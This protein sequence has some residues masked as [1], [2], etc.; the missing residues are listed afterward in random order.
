MALPIVRRNDVTQQQMT[1]SLA[2]SFLAK[3]AVPSNIQSRAL[4]LTVAVESNSS[5][6]PFLGS[7]QGKRWA[8]ALPKLDL[9]Q[10]DRVQHI[11]I[12]AS[13]I[14]VVSILPNSSG[15]RC[16]KWVKLVHYHLYAGS[17]KPLKSCRSGLELGATL[18]ACRKL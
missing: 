1:V 16:T 5:D 14:E 10:H 3:S 8:D 13:N 6:S 4:Y 15:F 7:K 17:D 11:S 12:T 9:A 18:V 2:C